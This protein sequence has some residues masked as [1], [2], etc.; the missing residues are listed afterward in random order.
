[1][2]PT[3]RLVGIISDTFLDFKLTSEKDETGKIDSVAHSSCRRASAKQIVA[4]IA[5]R[6]AHCQ[7]VSLCVVV[8]DAACY[9]P[10]PLELSSP[11]FVPAVARMHAESH[12][13]HMP[14]I[15]PGQGASSS[16]TCD[17]CHTG[18]NVFKALSFVI[19]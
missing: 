4:A 18:L 8:G 12:T 17:W 15:G 5:L 13:S 6:H 2:W 19:S 9:Y 3:G 14:F 11:E 7:H 16:M 1:M 10:P